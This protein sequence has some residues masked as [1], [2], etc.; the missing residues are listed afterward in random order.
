MTETIGQQ[1]KQAREAKGILLPQ[2]VLATRIREHYLLALEADDFDSLPSPIQARA[3]LRLY[4]EYLGLSVED[5]IAH[6]KEAVPAP[7]PAGSLPDTAEANSSVTA[8]SGS[9]PTHPGPRKG[10]QIRA[11]F[12]QALVRLQEKL[13]SRRIHSSSAPENGLPSPAETNGTSQEGS[14]PSLP[15]EEVADPLDTLSGRP[16]LL[17]VSILQEIGRLLATRRETLSL[18]LDEIEQ[19]THVRKHYLAALE[20]GRFDLLPSSV[21][22]RGMLNNYARFLDLDP[23]TVLLSFAE[24]LQLQ[25]LERQASDSTSKVKQTTRPGLKLPA[26]LRRY[27]SADILAGVGLVS[28]LL[29]FSVWGTSRVIQAQSQAGIDPTAPSISDMLA[30]SPVQPTQTASP[31]L[32]TETGASIPAGILTLEITLPPEGSGPVQV[33]VVA[34]NSAWVRVTVDGKVEFE[35]RTTDGIAYPYNADTQIEVL[36]GNGASTG[37]IYNQ[38][39]LGPMGTYGE[40]VNRIYTANAILNPTPTF[41]LTPS[42]TPIPSSTPVPSSTPRPSATPRV[43]PT[44]LP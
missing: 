3:F 16:P 40:V 13:P 24:S 4:A 44:L 41:T 42:I 6:Q 34:F 11:Y 7:L 15:D 32:G 1:L 31:T 14:E 5:L 26:N 27:L 37:I 21:Q 39:D 18:T 2:V 22:A 10:A 9:T 19:H 36:T 20:A 38:S 35:G 28:L 25:R 17:S 30:V 33:V 12:L 43:S 8:A 29:I 23:D